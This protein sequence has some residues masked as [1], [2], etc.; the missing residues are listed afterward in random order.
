MKVKRINK[1]RNWVISEHTGLLTKDETGNND[2]KVKLSL[3]L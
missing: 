1:K 3:L 2:L